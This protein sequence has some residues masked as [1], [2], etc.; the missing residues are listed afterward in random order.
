MRRIL[1]LALGA[2][3]ACRASDP[4][5]QLMA[6]ERKQFIHHMGHNQKILFDLQSE[7][8]DPLNQAAIN[9]LLDRMIEHYEA[10]KKIRIVKDEKYNK[11]LDEMFDKTIGDI[12]AVR[13][14]TWTPSNVGEYF[15][16]VEG[17]CRACHD[18]FAP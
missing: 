6:E 18:R 4:K 12:R 5:M 3:A 1:L 11:G 8:G 9:E 15:N 14:R 2:M 16:I 7:T 13:S 17:Q 10:S